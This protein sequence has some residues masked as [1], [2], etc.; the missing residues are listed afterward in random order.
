[1]LQL[2]FRPYTLELHHP[3]TI[4]NST[5]SATP[6]VMLQLKYKSFVGYG[7]ASLPPYLSETQES[8]QAFL[9]KINLSSFSNPLE[10]NEIL[11][12]VMQLEQG[13]SAAK[14][15]FDIALHD[16]VGKILQQP[17]HRLYKA[18]LSLMPPTS[19]TIGIDSL[20]KIKEKVKEATPFSI[21]KVK[22][23][24]DSDKEIIETIRHITNKP[25]SVDANQGW[26]NKENA[27]ELIQ[28]LSTKNILFIEQPLPKENW[29]DAVWLKQHSPLPIIADEAVQGFSDLAN[30]KNAFHG[31][32]IKLMKCAGMR[33]AH[34]MIQEARKLNLKV[35]IGCMNESSCANLAA[36][37]LA[38]FA[39]WVDLDGPFMIRNNPFENPVLENGK[40]MLQENPGIGVIAQ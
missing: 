30:L 31:I 26:K 27:L 39:D 2:S 16:L 17:W 19:L 8:V 7:E 20:E 32:N 21:L 3:F 36:A 18:D 29:D 35:L 9:A 33:E 24:Q 38:P 1:M 13:N 14:A 37:Q 15:S 11:D 10:L 4:A 34:K 22:L 6:V 5:R 23:G 40:I 12:Y 25:L 28:W